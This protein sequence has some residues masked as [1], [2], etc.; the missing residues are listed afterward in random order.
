MS[1]NR[2]VPA[3]GESAVSPNSA[4]HMVGD[5]MMPGPRLRDGVSDGAGDEIVLG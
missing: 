2:N 5:P 3:E 4:L 1:T